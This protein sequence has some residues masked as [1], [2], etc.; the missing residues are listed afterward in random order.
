MES[1]IKKFQNIDIEKANNLFTI[2][3]NQI[4]LVQRRGYDITRE[5]PLYDYNLEQFLNVYIPFAKKQ[6]KSLRGVLSN[7]YEIDK[8]TK[9]KNSTKLYVHY[10]EESETN[11][12]GIDNITEFIKEMDRYKTKNG[13]LITSKNLSAPARKKLESLLNYT[14]HVFLE[15]EM[16]YDPTEHYLVP[17]HRGL[18]EE[19]QREF[20]AKNN[21]SITNFKILLTTDMIARYYGF[22]PGQVV[23]IKRQNMFDTMI[24]ESIDYRR[25]ETDVS[26]LL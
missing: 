19:E 5:K 23:E 13:I 16:M 7:I 2:K 14:V 20:L 25:V 11:Q 18:C 12:L 4:K 3:I 24:P 26:K 22:K 9:C 15:R 1:D 21:L 10:A 17:T 8:N 6:N